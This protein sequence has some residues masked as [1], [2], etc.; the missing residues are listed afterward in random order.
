MFKHIFSVILGASCLCQPLFANGFDGESRAERI[1][2]FV[3][4]HMDL[5]L[6]ER[7]Q[8]NVPVSITL[9]QAILESNLGE[10]RLA[11]DAN[12]FFGIKCHT[13]Q[14][15]TLLI[16]DDDFDKDGNLI[17]SCFRSYASVA[18]SFRDHSLF[19]QKDRYQKKLVGI[20]TLDYVGWANAL[21]SAGYATDQKYAEKLIELIESHGLAQYDSEGIA[22]NQ[23]IGPPPPPPASPRQRIL[24]VQLRPAFESFVLR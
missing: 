19:L 13:W 2:V 10:S 14:G 7:A 15:D 22:S 8:F 17:E 18:E 3:Q 21:Q 1:Q 23:F 16:R 11:R 6:V 5:A 9:A 24:M 4:K 12:N 20:S